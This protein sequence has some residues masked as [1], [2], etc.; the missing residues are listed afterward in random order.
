MEEKKGSEKVRQWEATLVENEK[1]LEDNKKT[2]LE[3]I[4]KLPK[5]DPNRIK[6]TNALNAIGPAIKNRDAESLKKL[7][8]SINI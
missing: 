5:D 1:I 3:A 4:R 8:A 6:L 7:M 2:A